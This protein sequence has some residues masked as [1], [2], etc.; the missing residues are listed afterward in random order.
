MIYHDFIKLQIA[1]AYPFVD[2]VS[3]QIGVS[4]FKPVGK[5]HR[6]LVS[7]SGYFEICYS[8]GIRNS[9]NRQELFTMTQYFSI[10]GK[11]KV[12]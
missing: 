2:L 8:Q 11:S 5:L 7:R 1:C 3:F 12:K 6:I 10:Y 9:K 4:N